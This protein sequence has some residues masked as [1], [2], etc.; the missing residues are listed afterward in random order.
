MSTIQKEHIGFIGAGNMGSAIASQLSVSVPGEQIHVYDINSET[1]RRLKETL[2][3]TTA[4]SARD[5]ARRCSIIILAVK[6]DTITRV[7]D[8]IKKVISDKTLVLSIAAGIGISS[9]ERIIGD[10][11]R[12]IRIMP[13]TPSLIG[14]GMAVL[15][16][17]NTCSEEDINAAMSIFSLTG[18]AIVLPEKHMDAVTGVSGSGPAF[19]FTFIQAITDGGVKMGLPRDHALLLAAQTVLGAAKLVI[20][21]SEDPITLRGKVTS[22]GGTTIE[23]VH[24]LE[25]AGFS[26]SVIDAVEA[27]ALKSKKL[28]EQ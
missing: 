18:R 13:N 16:P 8:D 10:D 27:A 28:G 5:I 22:P 24:V 14:E 4:D 25:K 23:G 7:L 20:E 17:N 1:C 11:K 2:N 3:V 15:S 26:G 19:V 21:S 12:I 6:P 9:I